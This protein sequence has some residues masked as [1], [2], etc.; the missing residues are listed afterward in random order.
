MNILFIHEITKILLYEDH[1]LKKIYAKF[2]GL[3]HFLIGK[4]GKYDL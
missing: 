4:Y 2:L 1:K 3:L